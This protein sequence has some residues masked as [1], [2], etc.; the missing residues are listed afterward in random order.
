MK[1]H[2]RSL[3][4]AAVAGLVFTT[5]P[6]AFAQ[7]G[8][9][10]V[11]KIG[12]IQ[13]L[14]GSSAPN[15]ALGRAVIDMTVRE[16]NAAGGIA[17]RKV[18]VV[19]GDDGTDPARAV[20]EAKRL[21]DQEKVHAISGPAIAANALAAAPETTRAKILSLPFTGATSITP[22]VYPY[23]FA[24]FYAVDSF[25]NAMADYAID[26]LKF[27]SIG[28]LTDTGA[29]GKLAA[30]AFR[31]HLTQ[32]GVKIA[33][34]ESADFAATDV[35]PQTLNLRRAGAGVILQ[36]SSN[37]NTP[38]RLYMATEE[39]G[40]KVPIVSQ[41]S[42]LF[43]AQI[44]G[45]VGSNPFPSGRLI[46]LTTKSTTYCQGEKTA[47][48]PYV[49]FLNRVKAAVPDWQ[50]LAL[51]LA[52]YYYDGV[53]LIKAAIEGT[54]S[55]EGPRLAAWVEANSGKIPAIVGKMSASKTNHILYGPDV[56]AFTTR[57]DVTVDGVSLREGCKK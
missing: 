19:Y 38:A 33:A 36:V 56:F 20:A 15:G 1:S 9:P 28:V 24:T 48:L 16:I 47:D 43:P 54:K 55:V 3:L 49:K 40:W 17:G 37:Q 21:I 30:E 52:G 32:R 5:A 14:T 12:S 4:S 11:I 23:G 53:H 25:A 31:K 34:M 26:V 2:R 44:Q 50:K 13:P 27:T 51:P 18:E 42:A 22:Q 46:G 45:I 7:Q 57:P 35:L 41:V 39:M 29:Q 6:A 10:P 8:L